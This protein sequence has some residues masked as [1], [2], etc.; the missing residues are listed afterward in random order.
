MLL[1]LSPE[2]GD[3]ACCSVRAWQCSGAAMQ[4]A[5]IKAA[6]RPPPDRRRRALETAITGGTGAK[7]LTSRLETGIGFPRRNS[8]K[9]CSTS[10]A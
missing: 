1:P 7:T 4:S 8:M 5:T 3:C 6:S 2:V 10:P 9:A